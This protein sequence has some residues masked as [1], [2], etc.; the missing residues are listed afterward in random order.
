[1]QEITGGRVGLVVI[2]SKNAIE[3]AMASRLYF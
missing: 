1:L 2:C 3:M